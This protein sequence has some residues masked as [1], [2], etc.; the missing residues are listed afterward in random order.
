MDT[1][2]AVVDK[3]VMHI[4]ADM[5]LGRPIYLDIYSVETLLV[6]ATC[7]FTFINMT[8]QFSKVMVPM[9]FPVGNELVFQ[10]LHTL[11]IS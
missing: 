3:A 10:V 5:C 2:G 7:M 6:Q 4:F 8:E 9:V 1:F 11:V